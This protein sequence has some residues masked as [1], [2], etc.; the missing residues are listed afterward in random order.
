MRKSKQSKIIGKGVEK[1]RQELETLQEI[2]KK[3]EDFQ[4]PAHFWASYLPNLRRKMEERGRVHLHP[5]PLL[6]GGL[7]LLIIAFLLFRPQ[8]Y[9]PN[10]PSPPLK[11]AYEG[12]ELSG[13]DSAA[14]LEKFSTS[15]VQVFRLDALQKGVTELTYGQ[16]DLGG[17]GKEEGEKLLERLASQFGDEAN[18][19]SDLLYQ[20]LDIDKATGELSASELQELENQLKGT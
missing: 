16:V 13:I 18:L 9:P 8:I 15:L 1:E 11:G 10:I 19:A 17:L 5:I 6:A 20:D 14:Q 3:E 4:P 12:G 7:G 2:L